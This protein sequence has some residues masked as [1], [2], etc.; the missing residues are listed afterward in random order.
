MP[1]FDAT[2]KVGKS[3]AVA[4]VDEGQ[5]LKLAGRILG[6]IALLA[7]CAGAYYGMRPDN[8]GAEAIFELVKIGLLPLAT[9]V[10]SFYFSREKG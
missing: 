7:I 1:E 10:I 6:C 4:F 5:R 2:Q 3:E 8:A 9:L